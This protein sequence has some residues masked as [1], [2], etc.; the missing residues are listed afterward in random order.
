MTTSSL[1]TPFFSS[2][3]VGTSAKAA[4]SFSSTSSSSGSACSANEQQLKRNQKTPSMSI[5]DETFNLNQRVDG[6]GVEKSRR[7]VT[8]SL[9]SSSIQLSPTTSGDAEA[10]ANDAV[11]T[12]I[13]GSVMTTSTQK[14]DTQ[15]TYGASGSI[16]THLGGNARR[17]IVERQQQQHNSK[18]PVQTKDFG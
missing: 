15:S 10:S 9:S 1:N 8:N 13:A 7:L 2:N 5:L 14:L 6:G 18:F 12:Q 17:K 3:L 16:A 4:S 11:L